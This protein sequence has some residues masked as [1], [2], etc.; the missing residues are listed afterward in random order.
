MKKYIDK[1]VYEA[2]RERIA[3]CIDHF[4]DFYVSFSGGKDSGVLLELVIEVAREKN[5]LPVKAVFS[6]LEVIF[7]ETVEYVKRMFDRP[8]VRGFWLCLEELDENGSS[9]FERYFKI[10]DRNKRDKWIHQPPDRKDVIT[11]E[12]CPDLLKKYLQPDKLNYWSIEHFGEYLCDELKRSNI[13][14]FIGMRGKESYGRYM[15][16]ATEKHRTKV[17]P[18]TYKTKEAGDRTYISLP[19]YDWEYND[20]WHYYA[21]K[22]ADYNRIYDKMLKLGIHYPSM[23]TCSALGEEQKKT[24]YYWKIFEPE[25]FDR[26]LQRCEGVN[27]GS[28]YNH[29]N[30]NRGRIKKPENITWKE[31]LRILMAELPDIVRDNFK[32]KFEIAFRYHY[33]MYEVKEGIPKEVYI[34]DS[35]ADAR[36]VAK[37]R[38]MGIK[39]FISYQTLCEAIIKRDFVFKKYGFGYSKKMQERIEQM[40]QWKFEL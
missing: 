18:Y 10:W 11:D 12:N 37:E 38:G 39:Y 3:F 20:I 22:N 30:I 26:M 32:E 31:Y 1:N 4:E 25:T 28:I 27:F 8:E 5:R 40:E 29:T 15:C 23:R 9:I 33:V 17:N 6:D 21:L 16:I 13:C 34:Q 14:N 7:N 19:L 36:R 35:R 2:A 24:L